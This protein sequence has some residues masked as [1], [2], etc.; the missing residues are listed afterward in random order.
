MCNSQFFSSSVKLLCAQIRGYD[1][2]VRFIYFTTPERTTFGTLCNH[3]MHFQD[4]IHSICI[5]FRMRWI[6]S[7]VSAFPTDGAKRVQP[8]CW[9]TT[10]SSYPFW[11]QPQTA[12]MWPVCIPTPVPHSV[13]LSLQHPTITGAL[14]LLPGQAGPSPQALCS[15]LQG[16]NVN[17]VTTDRVSALH[18]ACLGGHV[19]CAKLLLENGA[20]VSLRAGG[21]LGKMAYL[22][23]FFFSVMIIGI[24]SSLPRSSLG[25][26]CK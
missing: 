2:W 24:A 20:Q 15:A 19:A 22:F 7:W 26:S 17:L 9:T 16:F 1:L 8:S 21:G 12:I 23:F 11:W 14:G 10:I 18:E 6:T 5:Y 4:A 3:W 13:V 25:V